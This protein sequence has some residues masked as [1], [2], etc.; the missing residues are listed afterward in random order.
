[1]RKSILAALMFVFS[2]TSFAQ[3][4]GALP[5]LGFQQESMY[6][7]A[8]DIGVT[9]PASSPAGFY[10][11]PASLGRKVANNSASLFFTPR[12]E[13]GHWII[14]PTFRS[15]GIS[16][17]YDL[18]KSGWKLPFSI[19]AAIMYHKF[20]YGNFPV[21]SINNPRILRTYEAFEDF[22][23]I[24]GGIGYEYFVK[25]SLGASIKLIESH[26]SESP[27]ENEE[28]TGQAKITA[29][30][31]GF[32][33]DIPFTKLLKPYCKTG[34]DNKTSVYPTFDL[35]LGIA[36]MNIGDEIDYGFP[37]QKDPILRT[38]RIGY[39]FN[40]GYDLQ[41]ETGKISLFNYSF[42][43]EA[44]DLLIKRS[45][46]YCNRENCFIPDDR[47][48][49]YQ[50]FL[51]DLQ[52]TKNL[53]HLEGSSK[54]LSHKAHMINLFETITFTSGRFSGKSIVGSRKSNAF[55]VSTKGLFKLV[56]TLS[57]NRIL[58]YITDHF[59]LS[60]TSATANEDTRWETNLYSFS[61]G[62]KGFEI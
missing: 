12:Q 62:Y 32:L 42:T 52:F 25:I 27:T 39:T 16:A 55:S 29:F 45:I 49:E 31:I 9:D 4:E 43:G 23:M 1:M 8:G 51:S 28:G 58:K 56:G 47:N 48:T 33:L 3:G 35:S 10:F 40:V 7:G 38:A 44:S 24:S 11:N 18:S 34:L 15:F 14:E 5:F 59:E 20:S 41:Y 50:G 2:T 61:I 6:L 13:Y 54:I 53:I 30:D 19:G 46:L 60:Y 36:A 17:G 37:A 26:L 21:T 22:I 57:E